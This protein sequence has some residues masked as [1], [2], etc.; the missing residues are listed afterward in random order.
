M[1]PSRDTGA[2][3]RWSPL[4][5]FGAA[6]CV[7]AL[8][9]AAAGFGIGQVVKHDDPDRPAAVPVPK[10][11]RRTPSNAGGARAGDHQLAGVKA[12][13]NAPAARPLFQPLVASASPVPPVSPARVPAGRDAAS[14]ATESARDDEDRDE[15][16]DDEEGGDD[17]DKK[18]VTVL[19]IVQQGGPPRALL[20][21]HSRGM[22]RYV[23]KGDSFFDYRV[24]EIGSTQVVLERDGHSE[25][26]PYSSDLTPPIE[27]LGGGSLTAEEF[28]RVRIPGLPSHLQAVAAR[29]MPKE[30]QLQRVES[31]RDD[32]QLFWEVEKS[33]DGR[34]YE[35][36]LTPD[37]TVD[38]FRAQLKLADVPPGIRSAAA[39][40]LPGYQ[41]HEDGRHRTEMRRGQRFY[42]VEVR[43]AEGKRPMNIRLSHDGTVLRVQGAGGSDRRR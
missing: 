14:R 39:A 9:A 3:G 11:V 4:K 35:L 43:T 34:E 22:S 30:G 37:G 31:E 17:E 15:D 1:E 27:I 26:I 32:G 40:A 25:T 16:E 33:V 21:D 6:Q 7:F 13:A 28:L 8:A 29:F 10:P 23:T 2:R 12:A 24:R 5:S 18:Q 42:E 20:Q 41:A 38:R 19:G 36:R